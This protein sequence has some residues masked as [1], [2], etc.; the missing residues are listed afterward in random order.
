METKRPR[1]NPAISPMEMIVVLVLLIIMIFCIVEIK[2][3]DSTRINI[4]SNQS[5]NHTP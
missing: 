3:D 1:K 5:H 2:N 4:G